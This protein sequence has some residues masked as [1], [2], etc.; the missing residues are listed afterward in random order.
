MTIFGKFSG[1][2]SAANNRIAELEREL[3]EERAKTAKMQGA[4]KRLSETAKRVRHGDL[5]ARIT[6]WDQYGPMSKTL[7]DFNRV[8]DL[9]DAYIR[10]AEASLQAASEHRFYRRFMRTGM[11]GAFGEGA[12]H[13]NDICDK[14][15]DAEKREHEHRH[16]MATAFES[17]VLQVVT[18]LTSAV[19]QVRAT[20]E[21][22]NTF[23]SENQALAT[24]VAAAAE[25]ATMNVQ[26]VA[27]AAEELSASV[28]E[29]ARQVMSSSERSGEASQEAAHTSE[30]IEALKASS[31]TI[32]DVI[33]LINDIAEQTNLL[34]LNATIEAARAGEAG[35]GFAVVASEVK[36]LAQQTAN[37][38]GEIGSQVQSIQS[39]TDTTVT[40]VGHIA[41]TI[42]S[43]NEIAAAIASAT[44]Q[45]SAA[46]M[47]ISR[48]I[49]EASQGTQDVA[50]NIERV[51]E[52]ASR[53]HTAAEELAH[54]AEDLALTVETL[55]AQSNAFIEDVRGTA[56]A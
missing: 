46:T 34:A 53:T 54:A 13:I 38:T 49:Q 19:E 1:R 12:Q 26:T 52:T 6:D 10:E 55:K 17:S 24:G 50:S 5:E 9:T 4:C 22:L 43:L 56:A 20:A 39:N 28:E 3:A 33:K 37:A 47:E 2:D 41:D 15:Q 23:A 35:K 14:M 42:R 27:S 31:D 21:Q 32:G 36:S 44:E 48:N 25:Q 30:T 51:S 11:A 45:Q 8:L 40:A 29:I 7:C 18:T 16:E